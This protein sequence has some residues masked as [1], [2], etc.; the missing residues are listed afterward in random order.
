MKRL[1]FLTGILA[2]AAPLALAQTSTWTSD[3][4]HSEVDFSIT[5]MT[6]SNIHGRFGDVAATIALNDADISKSTVTAAIDIASV[7][8]GVDARNTHIKTPDFFDAIGFPKA[9]RKSTRLN[10]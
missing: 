10:S 1:A 2:L 3:P 7:D 4:N 6:V 5:H 9:D 8:T